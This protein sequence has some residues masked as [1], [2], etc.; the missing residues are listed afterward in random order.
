MR[1]SVS[2]I[3]KTKGFFCFVFQISCSLLGKGY[4]NLHSSQFRSMFKVSSE[5]S[6]APKL[7]LLLSNLIF[8][9]SCVETVRHPKKETGYTVNLRSASAS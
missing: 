6:A 3:F 4:S 7:Y 8:N 2:E 1:K 5:T 9:H